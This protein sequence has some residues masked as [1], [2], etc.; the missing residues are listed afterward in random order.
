MAPP[1]DSDNWFHLLV[2]HQN[3][4]TRG[5]KNFIPDDCLPGFLDLV[6]WGHEHDCR[7][8]PERKVN[9]VFVSQPG[10]TV[11]TSLAAGEALPKHV[12]ILKVHQKDFKMMPVELKSVRPFIFDEITLE[13]V[14]G[15][16]VGR[17]SNKTPADLALIEVKKKIEE[18]IQKAKD[19]GHHE[20]VSNHPLIRLKVN[21]KN[22]NQLFNTIRVG[23]IYAGQVANP[24]DMIKCQVLRDKTRRAGRQ[25]VE[26]IEM[27]RDNVSRVE[28]MVTDYFEQNDVLKCLP[29]TAINETTRRFVDFDDT[30]AFQTAIAHMKKQ[31]LAYLESKM[32][33][34]NEIDEC[35]SQFK[36]ETKAELQRSVVELLGK[37]TGSSGAAA[38]AS[39]SVQ[40]GA[41]GGG[42][43]GA[44]SR[45]GGGRKAAPAATTAADKSI[46]VSDEEDQP[47]PT[48]AAKGRRKGP[49]PAAKK[50]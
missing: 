4:A 50:R 35:I 13:T 16:D 15:L 49:A 28:D 25:A 39:Q 40:S 14:E 26:D 2:W 31:C 12:G 23:Q 43:K 18:M 48:A 41:A 20:P 36:N 44:S 19:L 27:E 3:R 7:I 22:E 34:A 5:L 8:N 29:V 6:V 33:D 46:E 38:A 32:P 10:S 21:C 45:R 11:A 24:D 37:R 47:R 30:D 9:D 42:A 1:E 17:K